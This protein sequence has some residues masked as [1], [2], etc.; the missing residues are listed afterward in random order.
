[1]AFGRAERP[2]HPVARARFYGGA[3]E[4]VGRLHA[5]IG[6][7]HVAGCGQVDLFSRLRQALADRYR[8]EREIGHGGTGIVF[9]AEDLK[10]GRTVV[11]AA[12]AECV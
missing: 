7:P 5:G 3:F 2:R 8:I 12:C 10:H 4:R 9:I 11:P 1:M 6:R